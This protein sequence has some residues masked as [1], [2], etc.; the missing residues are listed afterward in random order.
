VYDKR[1]GKTW[2]CQGIQRMWRG[3]CS[4]NYYEHAMY[5]PICKWL[6]RGCAECDEV[7]SAKRYGH[8]G[9]DSIV[10]KS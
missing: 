10:T 8:G 4:L 1:F 5:L 7:E 2:V 6:Q 9:Y 3:Y